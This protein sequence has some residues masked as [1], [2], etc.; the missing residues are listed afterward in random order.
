MGQS[1]SLVAFVMSV[2]TT[3]GRATGSQDPSTLLFNIGQ[4]V[5]SQLVPDHCRAPDIFE[6]FSFRRVNMV[7]I[8]EYLNRKNPDIDNSN[9]LSGFNTVSTSYSNISGVDNW[10]EFNYKTL[11]NLYED[12]LDQTIPTVPHDQ[13]PTELETEIWDE[14]QLDLVFSPNTF[15]VP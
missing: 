1:N 15:L 3:R 4:Y 12:V 14:R 11:R 9:T 7:T 5:L 10:K 13:T 6:I 2:S 8:E